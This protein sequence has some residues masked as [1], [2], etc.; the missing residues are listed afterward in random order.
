MRLTTVLA[1]FAFIAIQAGCYYDNEEELYPRA[2]TDS[3]SFAADI[4]PMINQNCATSTCHGGPEVHLTTYDEIRNRKDLIKQRAVEGNPPMPA[5][6]LMP[7]PNRIKLGKWIDA[8][9]PNN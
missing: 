7:E 9:A 1:L 2:A 4:A 6:G 3:V 5:A 8:G